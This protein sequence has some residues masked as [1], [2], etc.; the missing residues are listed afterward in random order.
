MAQ[1]EHVLHA[2]VVGLDRQPR[3]GEAG[4]SLSDWGRRARCHCTTMVP[5]MPAPGDPWILQWY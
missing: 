1:A 4:P 3:D 2:G 5:C